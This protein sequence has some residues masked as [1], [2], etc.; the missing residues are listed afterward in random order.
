MERLC[1][2]RFQDNFEFAQWFKKV[3]LTTYSSACCFPTTYMLRPI[4]I[5]F[6][7]FFDANYTGQS[8][9]VGALPASRSPSKSAPK[10]KTAPKGLRPS[11]VCC[12]ALIIL[13]D[14]SPICLRDLMTAVP[15]HYFSA[16]AASSDV[17]A[18]TVTKSSPRV[19]AE[20]SNKLTEELQTRVTE[21]QLTI[22][23]TL[24]FSRCQL[25]C[26]CLRDF[27]FKSSNRLFFSF[28]ILFYRI[29]ERT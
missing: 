8:A 9:P 7:Q 6:H 26:C 10:K 18:R 15:S 12:Y 1:K 2:G 3:F 28:S 29:G 21:L 23:G 13:N 19:T 20:V 4:F 16:A 22:D 25:N 14:A 27:V 17:N 24:F 5:L 11:F